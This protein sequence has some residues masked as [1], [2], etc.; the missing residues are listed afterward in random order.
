MRQAQFWGAVTRIM[1]PEGLSMRQNRGQMEGDVVSDKVVAAQKEVVEGRHSRNLGV[2]SV[3]HLA[4][5]T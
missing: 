2:A 1:R 4:R 3:P 5:D